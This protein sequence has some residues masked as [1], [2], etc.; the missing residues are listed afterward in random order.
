MGRRSNSR[1]RYEYSLSQSQGLRAAGS[2]RRCKRWSFQPEAVT[3]FRFQWCAGRRSAQRRHARGPSLP[4]NRS[5][6]GI[7]CRKVSK[8]LDAGEE[9]V[10]S[11]SDRGEGRQTDNFLA[12]RTL[13]DFEF[14]RAVL[15]SDDRVA[16]IAE[17]VKVSIVRPDVLCELELTNEARADHEGRNAALGPVLGGAFR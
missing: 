8:G 5:A 15:V 9:K 10:R 17:F 1:R 12:D 6:D 13:G 3:H 14:Q 4:K 16:F 11:A 7:Q 2:C